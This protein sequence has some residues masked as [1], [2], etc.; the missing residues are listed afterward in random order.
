M[1]LPAPRLDN[2]LGE[3][4]ALLRDRVAP[5]GAAVADLPARALVM[6]SLKPAAQATV[7]D[8]ATLVALP[9]DEMTAVVLRFTA[10]AGRGGRGG[11]AA[12]DRQFYQA[13][14]AALRSLDFDRLSR[15]A[16]VDYLYIRQ[17][18]EAAL[19]RMDF[20]PPANIP[21][22]T[23]DSGIPGPARGR[24]GLILDLAAETI[25]YTPEQLI[26]LAN[27]EFARQEAEMIRAA[28]ELGFGDDWKRA[29]AHVKD[30]HEPP[31]GQ[32]VIIR[33]MLD[34]AVDYLRAHQL[35]T[36]P[37]VAAETFRMSMM[38]PERQ[39]VNPFFTG[40]AQITLSYPTNTME[41]DARI[42][43]MRGNAT[44]LS[45]ATAHHEMIPG[46]NLTAYAAS[47]YGAMY[48]A[49]VGGG[50]SPFVR[51]GW[52]VYWE[53]ILFD[54]GFHDTPAERIG[55][56]F[57]LMHRSARII[58][59]LN[60]HMGVWSPQECIDFLVDKV[61]HERDN[62]TAE[63]RRSFDPAAG[64]SPLYQA[65]YLLGALQLRG[66]RAE[67]VESKQ[68]S[69]RAFH[70]EIIRQGAMPIGFLRLALTGQRLR[71]DMDLRWAFYGEL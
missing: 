21:R 18:C 65:A 41:Y 25:P 67:L 54:R 8:L 64:Y 71:P 38:S 52:A 37:Q 51:E 68:M 36:V 5:A 17:T 4:A 22:R 10:G 19:A 61:G 33:E 7:P 32:P 40:G 43:S 23:D 13:W 48:R 16:Q 55:A 42:Q 53:T 28:R 34:E 58:F 14:L 66:L 46:H 9:H 15:N 20:R 30:Q 26:A 6:P 1:S 70:D 24:D 56:L 45:H 69:E 12:P 50:N 39:L 2:A 49:P 31:G 59:S 60:F 63:V 62:A 44:A 57:W 27:R 3:Y 29:L 47:R 35:I 11:A